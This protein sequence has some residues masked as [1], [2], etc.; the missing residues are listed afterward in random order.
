MWGIANNCN[1]YT[2]LLMM[3]VTRFR[4]GNKYTSGQ[5]DTESRKK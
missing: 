5:H 3:G 1:M 4:Q 2:C